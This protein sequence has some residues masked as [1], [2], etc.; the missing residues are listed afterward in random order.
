MREVPNRVTIY[1]D[2]ETRRLVQLLVDSRPKQRQHHVYSMVFNE[3][4]NR[5]IIKGGYK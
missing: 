5:L 4:L 3:G 1:L 2:K